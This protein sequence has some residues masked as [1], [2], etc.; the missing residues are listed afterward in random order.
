[1][2]VWTLDSGGGDKSCC[3]WQDTAKMADPNKVKLSDITDIVT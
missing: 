1:M 2:E 3:M